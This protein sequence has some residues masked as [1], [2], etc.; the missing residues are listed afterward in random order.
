M[1][2]ESKEQRKIRSS[3]AWVLSSDGKN[4]ASESPKEQGI[5]VLILAR[6]EAAILGGTLRALRMVV[7][8]GD[9][10]HVVADHCRDTTASVARREGAIVHVRNDG[11]PTG[12]GQALKWWLEET[13]IGALPDEMI[14]VLDA[15]SHVAPNFFESIRHRASRG[16]NV[17][18]TRVE[19]VVYSNSIVP[20]LAAFSESTEQRVNDALRSKLGWSVRLRGTGM[21]FRRSLLERI[22]ERVH[23]LVEDVELTLQLAAEGERIRFA[24]ET[25]VAD[26]KP[27]DQNG[28][29]RQR[30]RWLRGQ[31][32]VVRGYFFEIMKLLLR[33]PA[34]WSLLS[35]VLLKP[36]TLVI[37]IKAIL[38]AG[39]WMGVLAWGGLFWWIALLGSLSLAYD[40][41]TLICGVRFAA[42]RREALQTLALSPIYLLLWVRSMA[43]STVSGNVWL[44]VRPINPDVP[45]QEKGLFDRVERYVHLKINPRS[46]AVQPVRADGGD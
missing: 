22:C 30:A 37:P 1:T 38:T 20:H 17:I 34:G 27:N 29:M 26:P 19:P 4:V 42:N 5:Q 11:G 13:R 31:A 36:K 39:A 18:Q 6:N 43:L 24:A 15:D 25:Y 12:K 8:S 21:V 32:Q 23:T 3:L 33:G 14:V 35:S 10:I 41:G 45:V 7:G 40:L 9:K 46:L 44:R 16:E 2:V 28:A